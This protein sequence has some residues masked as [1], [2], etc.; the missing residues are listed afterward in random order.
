[1]KHR[2]SQCY[3]YYEEF[4]AKW[5]DKKVVVTLKTDDV[6]W[7]CSK[8]DYENIDINGRVLFMVHNLKL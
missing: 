4:K 5:Y 7:L 1:M 2:A 6:S 8:Y 3:I